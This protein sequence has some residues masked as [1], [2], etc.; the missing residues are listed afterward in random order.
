MVN[1]HGIPTDAEASLTVELVRVRLLS[2]SLV[3]ITLAAGIS[4]FRAFD[5]AVPNTH[6]YKN[7]GIAVVL[8]VTVITAYSFSRIWRT[9]LSYVNRD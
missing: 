6:L 4:F 8:I 9:Y 2:H 5:E 7:N 1:P 3:F